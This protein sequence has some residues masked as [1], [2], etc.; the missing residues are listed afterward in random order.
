MAE[1]VA[2]FLEEDA[3]SESVLVSG[4]SLLGLAFGGAV[5]EIKRSGTLPRQGSTS[6][7]K[8]SAWWQRG[9]AD[10]AT[11]PVLG[12]EGWRRSRMG[13]A[14]GGLGAGG[15]DEATVA[16]AVVAVAV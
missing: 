5:G 9:C 10:G 15:E 16:S 7:R 3:G 14:G 13:K 8:G 12:S 4:G 1:G 11:V 2:I 6:T